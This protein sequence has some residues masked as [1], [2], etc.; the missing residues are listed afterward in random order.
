MR[1]RLTMT[2][3]SW[4]LLQVSTTITSGTILSAVQLAWACD[5]VFADPPDW[6]S[7]R[8]CR[9]SPSTGDQATRHSFAEL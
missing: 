7:R 6:L 2:N 3:V 5:N 8:F 1:K 4:R 9:R